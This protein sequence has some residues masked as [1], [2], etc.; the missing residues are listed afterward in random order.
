MRCYHTGH[1]ELRDPDIRIG[2]T[3]ADFGQGFYLSPS[4]AFAGKW[5]R[6]QKDLEAFVNTYELDLSGLRVLRLQRDADWF[7]YIFRNRAGLSDRYGEYD[8]IVG[9]IANDTIYNTFGVFTSGLLPKEQVLALLQIG[10]SFEQI[11]VKTDRARGQLRWLSSRT[12]DASEL[13]SLRESLL[14]EEAQYQQALA[15]AFSRFELPD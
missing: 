6:E 11:V 9:P 10:P 5:V 12:L 14:R 13:S 3:N 7:D 2:R 1:R 8:V 15:Y 4:E